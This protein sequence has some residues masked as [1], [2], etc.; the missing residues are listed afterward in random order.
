MWSSPSR[1]HFSR[2]DL[3]AKRC[4]MEIIWGGVREGMYMC[5]PTAGS[6]PAVVLKGRVAQINW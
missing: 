2:L 1:P 3:R 6:W 4:G 5:V